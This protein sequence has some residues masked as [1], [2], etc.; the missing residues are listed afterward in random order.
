MIFSIIQI[1]S[2]F[3][4]PIFIIKH[5][6]FVISKWIG[7][8]G[9]AYVLGILVAVLIYSLNKM[10]LNI[11]PNSDIGEIG[12]HLAI[13]IAIP[14][15]LFSAN[16]KEAKKLSKVVLLSFG[17]LTLS[18]VIVSTI[19][20]Y[21]YGSTINFGAEL[22]GMAVGLYTGGTPNLNAIGN[23]F[24]VDSTTIG[25]A[26]LS[27]MVIGAVF[28]IFLLLLAKPLLSKFLRKS[29]K[30]VYIKETSNIQ[31]VEDLDVEKFQISKALINRF[32][33]ALGIAILGAIFGIIVWLIL[34]AEQGRMTDFL[35]PVMMITVTVLGIAASFNEK[36]R[37]TEGMNVLG[38]YFILVFSFAIASSLDFT[39]MSGLFN[40]IL[41]LYGVITLGVFVLHVIFS[42]FLNIDVDCT[43]TTL[44]AGVY[45]PAFVPAITK[46]L[47]NDNLTV[48]G[49]IIGSIGYAIGTF[50][51]I[52]LVLLFL[53]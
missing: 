27:D 34:G 37:K 4:I 47:K 5:H 9:T 7:T 49:L 1:L 12:S 35:V 45:G 38:Q 39:R 16:L 32:F 21:I 43:I 24:R 20:F 2:I 11:I 44:T 31:N 26:N 3:I 42:K 19:T 28:Y 36:I 18:A 22:S 51:G 17:S 14:L 53:L 46:Q 52:L 6:N 29:D 40:D 25:V 41:L 33:I 15:L 48:P 13:S 23:I 50:L 8:I 30:D 10:G